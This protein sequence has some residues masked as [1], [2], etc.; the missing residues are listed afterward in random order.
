M[1][2]LAMSCALAVAVAGVGASCGGNPVGPVR[3]ANAPPV[4]QVNDRV[5]IKEPAENL[6]LKSFYHFD[7]Y[8]IRA[9][10]GLRL[11]RDRRAQGVNALD[12]VPNS[13]W[14]TNRLGVR[15]VTPE[16]IRRGPAHLPDS[17][18]KHLPWTIK[19]SK[20]GGSAIGFVAEDSRGVK[21]I[22]K[23]D[24]KEE[25]ETE[26]AADVIVA[27][28]FWAAGWNVPSDHVV[29]F[30]RED[31]EIAKDAY[32]KDATGKKH[33]ID[34][35]F[36]DEQLALVSHEADGRIR[37]LASVYIA[38]K[39]VGGM[40]RVG[41]RK[42]DPNDVIPHELRRDVRGVHA[43][44]GWLAHADLKEDNT[45]DS[46]EED[47]ANKQVKYVVHY[48]IDFGKALGA[49]SKIETRWYPDYQYDID[50]LEM[51]GS[52]FSL[53]LHAQPWEGRVNPRMLGVGLYSDRDYDPGAYKPNTMSHTAVISWADRFDRFWASKILIRF[54][55]EQLAAAVSVGRLTQPASAAYL[56]ET[57]IKRQRRTA[58]YWFRRVNPIDELAVEPA[59]LCFVDLA[60]R[61]Q[62]ESRATTFTARAYDASGREVAWQGAAKAD[63]A[64]RAC[65]ASPP[66]ASG[67]DRYT[68][69]AI[70]NSRGMPGTLVHVA[71][72]PAT[73]QPRVVGIHRR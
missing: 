24:V 21:F 34:K 37:G 9:R 30:K 4:W 67:K 25:P 60:L 68:I 14:F 66:L 56:L 22:L 11:E 70:E 73:Q 44:A 7:T 65:L 55:R 26:T 39:P 71:L 28:I 40:T 58:Q 45:L 20:E 52:L 27:R 5:S 8:Y 64:G 33:P 48:L 16:E 36:V 31:L 47:P 57:L 43:M 50:L 62:L 2:G 32:V 13:T 29:Y 54:T 35:K 49:M 23:F 41:V 59:G 61:H 6:F 51:F 3:F 46:W 72:D 69:F 63:A 53:G 10:Y 19:S 42:D 17:P 38:G 12:E 18:E 15:E 1:R